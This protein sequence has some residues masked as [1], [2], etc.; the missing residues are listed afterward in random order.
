VRLQI[1]FGGITPAN[2]TF[3]VGESLILLQLSQFKEVDETCVYL[4]RKISVLDA[5]NPPLCSL[6]RLEVLFERNTSC[7]S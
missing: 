2:H 7:K 3:Q 4:E 1:G 6:V 5:K